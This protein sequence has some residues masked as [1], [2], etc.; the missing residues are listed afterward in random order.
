M[1]KWS[2][3]A[4]EGRSTT[5]GPEFVAVGLVVGAADVTGAVSVRSLSDFPERL[6]EL[7]EV[8]VTSTGPLGRRSEWRKVVSAERRG[9]RYALKLEGVAGREQAAALRGA[10]L[11]IPVAEVRP[12]PPGHWYRFEIIGLEVVDETGRRLGRVRDILETGANDVYV[13]L[14]DGAEGARDEILLPAL[15][16]VVL[17]V[18]LEAGRMVVRPPRVWGRDED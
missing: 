17:E 7:E 2:G 6:L 5:R 4:T 11:E 10:V 9:D 1:S 3:G 16:D 14:P 15:K 12:L 18:D 8:R 13:V